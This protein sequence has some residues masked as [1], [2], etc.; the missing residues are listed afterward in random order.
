MWYS[1]RADL[2]DMTLTREIDLSAVNKA[3][4]SFSEWYDIEKN[5]DYAYIEVSTDGGKT[6]DILTGKQTTTDNPNGASFG[7]AYTGRSVAADGQSPAQWVPE[8]MDLT[9]YAGKKFLL[10]FE[11]IT[12]DAYNAPGWAVD[13]I[14]IPEIGFSDNVESGANGWDAKGFVRTDNVLPQEY[15][16]QVIEASTPA[17]VVRIPLDSQNRGKLTITG[18]GKAIHTLNWSS[19]HL[20]RR[21]RSRLSMSLRSSPNNCTSPF[22]AE[23]RKRAFSIMYLIPFVIG[24]RLTLWI[25]A[26]TGRGWGNR[27]YGNGCE[28][29]F[30]F[31]LRAVI[32]K[33]PVVCYCRS[34]VDEP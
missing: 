20:R 9:P 12:D 23:A 2:A 29:K 3:T 7:P 4:L 34:P 30:Q 8:Q 14:S 10:R 31:A 1:N 15:I 21:R 18:L 17:Q 11:Y 33:D 5:F 27:G 28:G 25:A 16:V 22:L 24:T 19:P 26:R 32:D 6:W 13:D